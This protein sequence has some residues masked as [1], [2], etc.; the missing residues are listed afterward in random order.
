[1]DGAGNTGPRLHPSGK[2]LLVG[3]WPPSRTPMQAMD[4]Q[5]LRFN[6]CRRSFFL[7]G[8]PCLHA[9][10]PATSRGMRRL[11]SRPYNDQPRLS[12]RPGISVPAER[13]LPR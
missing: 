12:R 9:P 7:P 10:R 6:S 11:R 1:M 8:T 5:G 2:D 3:P 4:I 13:P